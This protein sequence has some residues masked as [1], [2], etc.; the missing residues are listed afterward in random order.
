MVRFDRH[1]VHPVKDHVIGHQ[2][3]EHRRLHCDRV[4]ATVLIVGDAGQRLEAGDAVEGETLDLRTEFGAEAD[5]GLRGHPLGE[6][7]QHT[8]ELGMDRAQW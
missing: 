3:D 1:R 2:V 6:L 7:G 4:V 5:V 8:D